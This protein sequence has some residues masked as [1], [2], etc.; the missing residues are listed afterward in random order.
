MR[1]FTFL[2]S[3][4]PYAPSQLEAGVLPQALSVNNGARSPPSRAFLLS[5]GIT[6]LA[7]SPKAEDRDMRLRVGTADRL[8]GNDLR[9][10]PVMASE[11]E[12]IFDKSRAA[13]SS[14]NGKICAQGG[15]TFQ[16]TPP[17]CGS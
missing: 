1:P 15:L 7:L 17:A 16:L 5:C 6:T 14:Q 13:N 10:L 4:P 2:S 3:D 8:A 12:R 11:T 9:A